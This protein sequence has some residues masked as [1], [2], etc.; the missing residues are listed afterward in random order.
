[1]IWHQSVWQKGMSKALGALGPKGLEPNYYS[2][3]FYSIPPNQYQLRYPEYSKKNVQ[4]MNP[5]PFNY[6]AFKLAA[7]S[8]LKFTAIYI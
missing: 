4:G 6:K 8:D 1:M 2:I 3:L 7:I 5:V